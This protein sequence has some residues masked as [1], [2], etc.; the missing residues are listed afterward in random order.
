VHRPAAGV[1]EVLGQDLEPIDVGLALEDV[2]E[3]RRAQTDAD[4]EVGQLP[5]I[6]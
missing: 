2:R 5:A 3:V 6:P 1:H 4:A